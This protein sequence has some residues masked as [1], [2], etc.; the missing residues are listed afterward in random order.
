M[1]HYFEILKY[2]F[3]FLKKCFSLS[4]NFKLMIFQMIR[5]SEVMAGMTAA[6]GNSKVKS[7][8]TELI[9]EKVYNHTL[10]LLE[11]SK[12]VSTYPISF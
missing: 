5:L 9:A 11:N 8:R 2:A 3:C 6:A 4:W 12:H 10:S 7:L 1:N